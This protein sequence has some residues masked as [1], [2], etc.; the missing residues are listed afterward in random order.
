MER[1]WTEHHSRHAGGQLAS[2]RSPRTCSTLLLLL[3]PLTF[4]LL[5]LRSPLPHR[6]GISGR[7]GA[8]Q[9]QA[10]GPAL[11]LLL[12]GLGDGE[13]ARETF[14]DHLLPPC[15]F[16]SSS[17]FFLSS[18]ARWTRKAKAEEFTF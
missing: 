17:S 3:L 4:T 12:L 8:G 1:S 13:E 18:T 14:L 16:F 6:G 10:R 5:L 11:V 2:R 7:R 9:V 15:S